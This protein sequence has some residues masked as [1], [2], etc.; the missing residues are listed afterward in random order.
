MYKSRFKK[1]KIQ[2]ASILYNLIKT[3][4]Y[5]PKIQPLIS[6]I[7][8]IS[9]W[10]IDI[11]RSVCVHILEDVNDHEMSDKLDKMFMKDMSDG[12]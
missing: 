1:K 8:E 5:L 2:E 4:G 3:E 12:E 9:K 10:D 11:A 7:N 6:K